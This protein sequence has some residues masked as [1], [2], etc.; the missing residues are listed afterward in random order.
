ML[1]R[2]SRK[3]RKEQKKVGHFDRNAVKWRNLIDSSTVFSSGVHELARS[4]PINGRV[5]FRF[6]QLFAVAGVG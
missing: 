5:N 2:N 4:I 1:Q 6:G 3:T